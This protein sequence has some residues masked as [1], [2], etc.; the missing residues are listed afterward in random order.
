MVKAISDAAAQITFRCIYVAAISGA[1]FGM[2]AARILIGEP[3]DAEMG[4]ALICA[5][6][7]G[8]LFGLMFGIL[9][10]LAGGVG[11]GIVVGF[12][13]HSVYR[14]SDK[15]MNYWVIAIL[16]G[17]ASFLPVLVGMFMFFGRTSL[18]F[19]AIPAL[20]AGV[21]NAWNGWRYNAWNGWRYTRS[22]VD[23]SPTP[24]P[25]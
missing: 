15:R 1:L 20:I 6:P 16:S 2:V 11:S 7:P 12:L 21:V 19:N 22:V 13:L 18:G 10:G 17:L 25:A 9:A 8:A 5:L 4:V 14:S 23:D 24:H 3:S